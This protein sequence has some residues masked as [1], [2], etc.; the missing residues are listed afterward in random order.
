MINKDDIRDIISLDDKKFIDTIFEVF[1]NRSPNNND[2]NHYR[3]LLNNNVSKERIIYEILSS[4]EG[5]NFNQRVIGLDLKSIE[6][7]RFYLFPKYTLIHGLFL[8]LLG[9]TPDIK[10]DEYYNTL[11]DNDYSIYKLVRGIKNSDEGKQQN[12]KVNGLLIA[13]LKNRIKKLL[14][15]NKTNVDSKNNIS[16]TN[17]SHDLDDNVVFDL[18]YD[19]VKNSYLNAEISHDNY[20]VDDFKK[21]DEYI[22]YISNS[23]DVKG[24]DVSVLDEVFS[25]YVDVDNK[26]S[27]LN[28]GCDNDKWLEYFKKYDLYCLGIDNNNDNVKKCLDKGF[29]VDRADYCNYIKNVHSSSIDVIIVSHVLEHLNISETLMLLNE[30]YRVLRKG[31]LLLAET[32]NIENKHNMEHYNLDIVNRIPSKLMSI[33]FDN[34]GVND[35]RILSDEQDIVDYIVYGVKG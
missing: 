7:S 25:K 30:C 18:L 2:I 10:E 12:T 22:R 5:V 33:I 21:S 1:L 3:S 14:G 32:N 29:N 26:V 20:L 8:A 15:I 34:I 13:E 28:L 4:I 16:N 31:G 27:V 17:N 11:L 24:Y 35:V 19:K 23:S 9:R 6:A